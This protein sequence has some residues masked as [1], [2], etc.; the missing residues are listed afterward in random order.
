MCF[1]SV[2]VRGRIY[3][4]APPTPTPTFFRHLCELGAFAAAAKDYPEAVI[5]YELALRHYVPACCNGQ[6]W[7]VSRRF[8]EEAGREAEPRR[9]AVKLGAGCEVVKGALP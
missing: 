6:A 2:V 7:E 8:L 4:P 9:C 5:W 1:V 3:V